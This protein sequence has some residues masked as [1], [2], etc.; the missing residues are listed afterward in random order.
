VKR[1]EFYY[2]RHGQTVFNRQRRLQGQ[3]DSPLTEKGIAD[4][5]K[6]EK[7]LRRIPFD[8]AYCSSSE[9]CVDTAAIV[10]ERHNVSAVPMK[11]LKEVCFGTLDGKLIEEIK[12]EFGRRKLT[13]D[14]GDLGGDTQESIQKR[15]RTTFGTIA[16]MSG[17]REKVLIVSHGNF[18]VLT[19]ET[20]FDMDVAAFT[21][22]RRRVD[23]TQYAFPNCGIM[24]FRWTDGEWE[25]VVS[26]KDPECFEDSNEPEP[27][28]RIG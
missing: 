10:L 7:A 21:E 4:A 3:C 13:T 19:L 12:E 18:G 2:V 14:Y 22:M 15:I 11:G 24:K 5:A 25:L 8:R 20:L 9:R 16:E 17:N 28:P 27:Y 1:V 23:P 26:P 6:A